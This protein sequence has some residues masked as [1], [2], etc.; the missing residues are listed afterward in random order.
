MTLIESLIKRLEK[1]TGPDRV[2]DEAIGRAIGTVTEDKDDEWLFLHL[3]Y[4]T[5][6]IDAA[7]TLNPYKSDE[8]W[9]GIV[10]MASPTSPMRHFGGRDGLFKATVARWDTSRSEASM[11]W[12]DVPAIALCIAELRARSHGEGDRHD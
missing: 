12:H 2:L 4:Y 8:G 6:S 3:P 10:Q 1:A 7:L 11:A 9:W 5:S